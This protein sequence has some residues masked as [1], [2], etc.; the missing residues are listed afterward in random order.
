MAT[1]QDPNEVLV[2][3]FQGAGRAAEALG[4]LRQL[5][6]E[7]LIHLKNAAVITRDASGKVAIHETHDFDAK[8]GAVA[9]AV[10]GGLLGLLRGNAVEGALLGAGAGFVGSK[11][12]DLGFKDDYLKEL[13]ASLTPDSSAIVAVVTFEH[14]DQA[15]AELNIHGGRILRETLPDDVAQK[16]NAAMQG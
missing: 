15:I 11:V 13:S 2:V 7:H 14:A 16:L 6:K 10:A 4:N 5:N 3:L 8:Q 1:T 9:G 12:I